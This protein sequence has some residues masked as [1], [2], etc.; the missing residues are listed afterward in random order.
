MSSAVLIGSPQDPQYEEEA[1]VRVPH[2]GQ[3]VSALDS[4]EPEC[5]DNASRNT[6]SSLGETPADVIPWGIL[7]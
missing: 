3:R 5:R 4:S 7:E 2:E 6:R 1:V